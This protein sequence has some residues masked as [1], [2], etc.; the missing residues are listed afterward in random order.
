MECLVGAMGQEIREAAGTNSLNADH[1]A[2]VDDYEREEKR[3]G[4]YAQETG[5]GDFQQA[6]IGTHVAR[7]I[8]LIDLG[9][10]AGEWQG[11][12]NSRN[13]VLVMW[14]LPNETLEIEGVAKPFIV[15][16]FYTN[17]LGEK[18]NLRHDLVQWRG[19]DF[20]P[21]E[22]GKFDLQSILGAPCMIS[23]VANDKGKHKVGGVMKMPKGQ[24]APE[25]KN[26][27][28]AFWLDEFNQATFDG[29]SDGLKKI[30][31]KSPEYAE[32]V[33]GKQPRSQPEK[34]GHFDDMEDDIPF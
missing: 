7:C 25:A 6:P 31:Q 20:S 14:E 16:K 9:T 8:R 34:A 17:S 30:I 5:G 19:R 13:Q 12:P 10:Q 28:L 2:W 26:P 24:Q 23:I 21:E 33:N 11:K 1:R 4:R 15:S 32:A 18:A 3:M 27:L 22:L 29:L